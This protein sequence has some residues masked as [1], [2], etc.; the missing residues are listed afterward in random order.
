MKYRRNFHIGKEVQLVEKKAFTRWGE[1]DGS[2]AVHSLAESKNLF[3]L[4][5]CFLHNS[6]CVFIHICH[7]FSH[8]PV[9][10]FQHCK[11]VIE[12][13]SSSP[14]SDMQK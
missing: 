3:F 14:Q 8:S 4:N 1:D 13:K 5:V 10:A 6:T 9:I 2:L 11:Q 12:Q 7:I